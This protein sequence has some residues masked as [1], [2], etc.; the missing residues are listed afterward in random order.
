MVTSRQIHLPTAMLSAAA[1]LVAIAVMTSPQ[2]NADGTLD[3]GVC[4]TSVPEHGSFGGVQ[5]DLKI[6]LSCRP[7]VSGDYVATKYNV[8]FPDAGNSP[9]QFERIDQGIGSQFYADSNDQV[10]V[11]GCRK[12]VFNSVCGPWS[13]IPLR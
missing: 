10:F 12:F 9:V 3:N 11:Q 1:C 13:Q 5:G 6:S 2:A 8:R 7:Q 4:W